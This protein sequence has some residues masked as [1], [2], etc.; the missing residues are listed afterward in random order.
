MTKKSLIIIAVVT[1]ATIFII[2]YW[3]LFSLFIIGP[4]IGETTETWET[5]NQTFKVRIDK[6]AEAN[7]GF[8]PGAYYVYQ[9]AHENS[10]DWKT[11][12]TQRHDDP[13]PI[14]HYSVQFI[15]SQI[16]YAFFGQKFAVTM[17]TGENWTVWDAWEA[18]KIMQFEQY[19]LYPSIEEVNIESNGY[20][21]M[22]LYSI[23]NKSVNQP[24]LKTIDYGRTWKWE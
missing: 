11:I 16:G 22:R 1:V 10:D 15:N 8:V 23:S 20:G 3:W 21:R 18:N 24:E 14:L 19:K 17:D 7:G 2:R 13:N 6:H 12:F 4:Y 5:S 9:T